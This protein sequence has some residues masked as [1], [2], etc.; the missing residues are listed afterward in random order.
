VP[1]QTHGR[2]LR[3]SRLFNNLEGH[4]LDRGIRKTRRCGLDREL[5]RTSVT[6]YNK[7]GSELLQGGG[8]VVSARAL[9]SEKVM[10]DQ[11]KVGTIFIEE[12]TSVPNSLKFESEPYSNG[13]RSVKNLN[14]YGLEREI[15][16]VGW[17][18]VNLA[19]IKASAFGFD[20]EKAARRAL[21]GVLAN[22][23]SDNFNSLE[24]SQV[25][26]KRFLGLPYVTVSAHARHIQESMF[27][28]HD[29]RLAKRNQA[30]LVCSR[31]DRAG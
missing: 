2:G 12:G 4:E 19:Q 5:L 22:V 6:D 18:L 14:G 16:A 11:I 7:P 25:A 9:P 13:W 31:A 24:I 3:G 27:L 29:K 10:A 20:R 21:N 28:L 26:A 15:R 17:T 23:K 30:R 1:R 8:R